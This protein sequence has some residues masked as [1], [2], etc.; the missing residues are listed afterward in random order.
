MAR[1]IEIELMRARMG[2]KRDLIELIGSM[3]ERTKMILSR[4]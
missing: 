1:D 3:E 2:R 4:V